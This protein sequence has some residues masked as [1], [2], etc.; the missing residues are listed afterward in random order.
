MPIFDLQDVGN[1]WVGCLRTDEILSRRLEH[2][3]VLGPKVTQEEF[4]EWFF[5]GLSDGVSGDAVRDDFD[6]ASDVEVGSCSIG[7]SSIGEKFKVE[8]MSFKYF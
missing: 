4:V 3:V 1:D 6:D 7:K 8:A 5:I 2:H